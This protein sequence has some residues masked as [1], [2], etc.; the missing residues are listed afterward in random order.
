VH[1]NPSD[2]LYEVVA[3]PQAHRTRFWL[4]LFRGMML[5]QAFYDSVVDV[6]GGNAGDRSG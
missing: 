3:I 6:C 2:Q 1:N 5:V 4:V